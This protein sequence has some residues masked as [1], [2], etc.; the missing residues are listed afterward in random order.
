MSSFISVSG[1]CSF[2]KYL[3]TVRER[4]HKEKREVFYP[5]L[6]DGFKTRNVDKVYA[7]DASGMTRFRLF[8]IG[9]LS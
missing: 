2:F 8:V 5:A 1:S 3:G 9:S 6:I 7:A 4:Y